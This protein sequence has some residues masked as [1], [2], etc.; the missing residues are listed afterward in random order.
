MHDHGHQKSSVAL[1]SIFASV[2]L[3][4]TKLVTGILTGSM[5]IISE[6]A[7]SLLDLGAATLTYFAVKVGDRPPDEDHPYGHGKVESVSALIETGLLFVTSA[8][9]IY[10]SIR[11]LIS[12]NIE[13]EATWYA[14]AVI[15]LSIVVDISRSRALGRVAKETKSQALEA[16]A[17][18]FSSDIW[19]SAVVLVGLICV[20]LGIK[21]ADA[22]AAIAVSLFIAL[23]GYR[24]GKRTI[25]VLVDAAP[26]GV[27]EEAKNIAESIEGV[28]AVERVRVRPLGPNVFV[29]IDIQVSRKISVAKAHD[30]SAKV[31]EATEK[32]IP[33]SDILVKICSKQ[34]DNETIVDAVQAIAAKNDFS[35]HDVI[36]DR[37]DSKQYISYDVEVLDTLTAKEA[38]D[39]ATILEE[40]IKEEVGNEIIINS[41]IE[42]MKCE[43]ILSSELS[44]EEMESISSALNK[45]DKEVEEISDLHNL[46]VRKIGEKFFVSFHCLVPG[47]L[48]LE[49][50]HNVTSRFEYLMKDKMKDIKR[51]VIHIEPK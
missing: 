28:I 45:T 14:F 35:V 29:E 19:S 1:S 43:A 48:S 41:H 47:D 8:W 13:V 22:L 20:S 38:H 18:H 7:H 44:E 27:S 24:L 2:L 6:A 49:K 42:P 3:T 26:R 36:V 4:V 32:K 50:A 15:I 11:R 23:A 31:E 51:V 46:L 10:E 40:S 5:G 17:L 16:D 37:L 9:I 39:A 21:G 25:D 12:G 33:G 30:I 34:M